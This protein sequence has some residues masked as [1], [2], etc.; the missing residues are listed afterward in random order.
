MQCQGK[1]EILRIYFLA[2]RPFY[3]LSDG[4]LFA[5]HYIQGW[6]AEVKQPEPKSAPDSSG[7]ANCAPDYA[8][9]TEL[10]D[11]GITKFQAP[12]SY[13]LD[14]DYKEAKILNKEEKATRAEKMKAFQLQW[15]AA[16]DA[17]AA[18]TKGWVWICPP[19]IAKE[20]ASFVGKKCRVWWVDDSKLYT[21][22]IDAFDEL[23]GKHRV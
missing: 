12:A 8:W 20:G 13:K 6:P 16:M 15:I 18:S 5:Q 1:W 7:D 2:W 22:A 9:A 23:S 14:A 21:G 10:L 19:C 4:S 17:K 3:S 11:R